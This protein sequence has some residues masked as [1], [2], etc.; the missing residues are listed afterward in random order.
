MK[1]ILSVLAFLAPAIGYCETAP[2]AKSIQQNET[3][4]KPKIYS[5]FSVFTSRS[6]KS[7]DFRTMRTMGTDESGSV[8][9]K[10][11]FPNMNFVSALAMVTPAR[12]HQAAF[13]LLQSLDPVAK[14]ILPLPTGKNMQVP[15]QIAAIRYRYDL[16]QS[17]L[18]SASAV[19]V[20]TYGFADPSL[21]LTYVT[22]DSRNRLYK[23]GLSQTAPITANSQASH[24]RTKS[25]LRASVVA[26]KDTWTTTGYVSHSRPFYAAGASPANAGTQVAV[27]RA[28]PLI[29]LQEMDIVILQKEKNRSTA[30]ATIAY[31]KKA[32]TFSASATASHFRTFKD[33]SIW[34]TTLK[35]LGIAYTT[36]NKW[37]TGA[38]FNLTSA[39]E[40]YRAPSLP[41][42]W[43]VGVYLSYSIGE[44][45]AI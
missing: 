41:T 18:L 2:V 8:S 33:R 10:S 19:H 17:F 27:T 12:G 15:G 34:A 28:S 42:Q 16:S 38:S 30:S 5:R 43:N 25:T 39:I 36:K 29:D 23:F 1:F 37:E 32:F 21:G 6:A 35:P 4:M 3:A 7:T 20:D 9:E 13:A 26:R 14:R 45:P 11:I 22:F 44:Q 40:K 31:V 24:L